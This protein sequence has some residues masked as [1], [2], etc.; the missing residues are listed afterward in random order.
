M[1][2]G[3]SFL[4]V[5]ERIRRVEAELATLKARL[6]NVVDVGTGQVRQQG[7]G[8]GRVGVIQT[9]DHDGTGE[10]GSLGSVSGHDALSA[11]HPDTVVAS[12]SEGDLFHGNAT[13][14]WARLARPASRAYLLVPNATGI[15]WSLFA[16]GSLVFVNA[17]PQMAGLAAGASGRILQS[18]GSA[19]S[20]VAMSGDA[21]IAAGG[22]V[23]VAASH[24]GS[25]HHVEAHTVASHSDTTATGAELETL[26]DGSD[27]DALH[28]HDGYALLAGR[29][30]GQTLIGDLDA[31]GD[32]VLQATAHAT[33]TTSTVQLFV[34]TNAT[35]TLGATTQT[36]GSD[37]VELEFLAAGVNLTNLFGTNI[38]QFADATN[39]DGLPATGIVQF[40]T[41]VLNVFE[42]IDISG[43]IA[44]GGSASIDSRAGAVLVLSETATA[45]AAGRLAQMEIALTYT[46]SSASSASF[47]GL[48]MD[49][50]A[51]G[52]QNL[53]VFLAGAGAL[54][55][56]TQHDSDGTINSL[57]GAAGQVIMGE[58]PLSGVSTKTP[59]LVG[60][61]SA[62]IG[63]QGTF[64]LQAYDGWSSGARTL[65]TGLAQ[66][67]IR[68]VDANIHL[69]T[70]QDAGNALTLPDASGVRVGIQLNDQVTPAKTNRITVTNLSGV[71]IDFE[72]FGASA[73]ITTLIGLKIKDLAGVGSGTFTNGPYGIAQE[74][75][76]DVNW[77]AGYTYVGGAALPSLA[78]ANNSALTVDQDASAGAI[79][80]LTLD[81][82]D[83]SEEMI[84]FITTIG[85]G[86]AIEVVG[87]KTLTTTHF[88]KVTIPGGLTVYFPVG[89]I[90]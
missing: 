30:G 28:A 4:S 45:T 24:S 43:H 66:S 67:G 86:N 14:K 34:D 48:F 90:A 68:G 74:G 84:E 50:Q 13:P 47:R 53:A 5:A 41:G 58:N 59:Q 54:Q 27:A 32:L 55:F 6:G 51:G 18:D 12:P 63:I 42:D 26:T 36:F 49:V 20:Y 10:G 11:F 62:G 82:A 33:R 16:T 76:G 71:L 37:I 39:T 46:P 89:T 8:A 35:M 73:T 1:G 9:H 40:A 56:V 69:R 64:I 38:V 15:A 85:T 29:S 80:V 7:D 70:F 60:L 3:G 87:A 81:Q 31:S 65:Q 22:A 78:T 79:P 88:I 44:I 19:P 57:T 2:G 21:T 25:A 75:Q 17:T 23:T 77:L 83:I 52:D 61:G 72:S